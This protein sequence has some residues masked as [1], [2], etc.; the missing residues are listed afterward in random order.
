MS[1]SPSLFDG[2]AGDGLRPPLVNTSSPRD[3]EP[4]DK[5]L[6]KIRKWQEDRIE[7][8]LRGEYE[9]AILH[10]SQVINENLSTP[11]RIANVRVEGAKG[12]RV[13]FL[14]SLI[15]SSMPQPKD[16][17]DGETTLQ[18]V[19]H[20]T[21]R[22]SHLLQKSDI[23]SSVQA[24]I[25]PPS[26]SSLDLAGIST[27][28]TI[29]FKTTERGKFY[30]S[31]STE[32]GNNEG[33]ASASARIRNVFG[34]AETLEA[35][36]SLGTKTRRSFRGALSAPLGSDL[37]TRGEA[38]VYGM[39]RDLGSWASCQEGLRGFKATLSV[40]HILISSYLN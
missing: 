25:V 6:D 19:L 11:L 7:R 34:G 9:S 15:S 27:P 17:E 28:V 29:L 13:S 18:D 32:L 26:S 8:K 23:F 40:S 37:E 38:S 4:V 33:S 35:N 21:R 1:T 30:L 16:N 20:T 2:N 39:E 3:Q 36:I 22:I 10:L 24:S 31:S 14:N 12:T 5:D